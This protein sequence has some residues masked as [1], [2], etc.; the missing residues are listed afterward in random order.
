V[1]RDRTLDHSLVGMKP[2]VHS[3]SLISHFGTASSDQFEIRIVRKNGLRLQL[4]VGQCVQG[5]LLL[6]LGVGDDQHSAGASQDYAGQQYPQGALR[7]EIQ[8]LKEADNYG[9]SFPAT[10]KDA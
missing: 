10:L 8:S 5:G 2:R 4:V 1:Q 6:S 3:S 9:C 7:Q